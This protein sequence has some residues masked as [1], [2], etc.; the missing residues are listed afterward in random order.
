MFEKSALKGLI[1]VPGL[2]LAQSFNASGAK[3]TS[4][5]S[6]RTNL[7]TGP[8]TGLATLAQEDQTR[9][10]LV[11]NVKSKITDKKGSILAHI[12]SCRSK[13]LSVTQNTVSE[14]L[15]SVLN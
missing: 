3:L 11:Q 7:S 4:W 9:L 2:E 14:R 12:V 5:K 1:C 13:T 6:V 8:A 10:L 15:I